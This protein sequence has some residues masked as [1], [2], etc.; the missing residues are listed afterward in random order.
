MSLPFETAKTT[1]QFPRIVPPFRNMEG[2]KNNSR[3]KYRV[4]SS[5]V[6][7]H[8]SNCLGKAVNKNKGEL[9]WNRAWVELGPAL[10][11]GWPIHTL[12]PGTKENRRRRCAWTLREG[13]HI[14]FRA[15]GSPALS[16]RVVQLAHVGRRL[17]RVRVH[18]RRA[19]SI[20]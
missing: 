13:S 1:R 3:W 17:L 20:L 2:N 19:P 8:R 16:A 9:E 12:R 4:S 7:R 15:L 6:V 10:L 5:L 18:E 14:R 11:S